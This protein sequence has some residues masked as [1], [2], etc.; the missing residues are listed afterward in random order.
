MSADELVCN[1]KLLKKYINE[2]YEEATFWSMADYSRFCTVLILY[3]GN[4]VGFCIPKPPQPAIEQ[5]SVAQQ[6]SVTVTIKCSP[7]TSPTSI[8]VVYSL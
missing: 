1:K 4:A 5:Q 6:L 7:T 3:G 2:S 8:N